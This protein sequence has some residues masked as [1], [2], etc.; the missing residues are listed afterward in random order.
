LIRALAAVR[1]EFADAELLV[2]G[3]GPE[4][5]DLKS[6]V[7]KL[8]LKDCVFFLGGVYDPHLLGKYL[9][10]STA[11][12]LAGMGGISIND[13]MIFGLPVICSVCD[14]TEKKLVREGVNGFYFKDGDKADLASRIL[15]LFRNPGLVDEMGKNSTRIIKMKINIHT[16]IKGYLDAFNYV[17]QEKGLRSRSVSRMGD[18]NGFKDVK[19]RLR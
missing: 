6:L 14:G 5:V 3:E 19:H 15:S 13:A 2:I 10:A 18:R 9:M 7:E 12:V 17:M 4:E 16:V 8:G 1:R 11:Y